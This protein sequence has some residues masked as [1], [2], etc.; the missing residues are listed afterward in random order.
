MSYNSE[1]YLRASLGSLLGCPS[2]RV[3]AQDNN[4]SDDSA[5]ILCELVE[6]ENLILSEGN[7]GFAVAVNDLA[8]RASEWS[9]VLVLL[10]PDASIE[11]EDVQALA[12]V[13]A[14]A[15]IGAVGP[16]ITM[17]AG[18]SRVASGGRL[19]TI[20]RMLCHL[21]GLSHLGGYFSGHYLTPSQLGADKT[22]VDWVTGACLAVRTDEFFRVGGMNERW[23]MYAEDIDFCRRLKA[24]GLRNR[25]VNVPCTHQLGAS[26]ERDRVNT[27]WVENL[28]DLY[29]TYMAPSALHSLVWR[30]VV[31]AGFFGRSAIAS[32]GHTQYSGDSGVKN[33]SAE[34]YLAYAGAVLRAGKDGRLASERVPR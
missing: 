6:P 17:P 34:R 8:R 16:Y 23:F 24:I 28:Y 18:V 30:A 12:D 33:S 29:A 2:I 26:G 27:V 9:D 11:A 7:A 20:W 1:K 3:W 13:A 14:N 15:S 21:T 25:M 32:L 31:A 22:D 5:K 4:S 19:P 10:N